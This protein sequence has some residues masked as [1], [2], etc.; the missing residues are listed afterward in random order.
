MPRTAEKSPLMRSARQ[1]LAREEYIATFLATLSFADA[2]MA[3]RMILGDLNAQVDE[4]VEMK[5]IQHQT[6]LTEARK[7]ALLKLRRQETKELHL[8]EMVVLK[9]MLVDPDAG[10]PDEITSEVVKDL[11]GE[12]LTTAINSLLKVQEQRRKLLSS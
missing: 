11:D 6:K 8:A 7:E 4:V 1:Y 10:V 5:A 9:H 12:E 2:E 3:Y